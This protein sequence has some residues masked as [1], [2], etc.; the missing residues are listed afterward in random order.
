MWQPSSKLLLK[1][2]VVLL[3]N[4]TDVET[5]KKVNAEA[6]PYLDADKP[7]KASYA[8]IDPVSYVAVLTVYRET[9]FHRK[10]AAART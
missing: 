1:M 3:S 6:K 2:A 4:F 7:W 5:I 10:L 8:L 9:F